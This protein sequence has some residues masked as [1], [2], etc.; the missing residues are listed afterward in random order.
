VGAIARLY[1]G[2]SKVISDAL[3]S[4]AEVKASVGGYSIIHLSV[5]GK[6]SREEPLLSYLK[7]AQGGPDDGRLTAAE[8]FGLPLDKASLVVLSACETGRAGVTYGNE[9][10]GMVRALLYAGADTLVLTYWEVDSASTALWMENFYQKAQTCSASE[11]ARLALRA[12]KSQP[13][14]VHP[15]YWAAFMLIG[16]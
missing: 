7:F 15:Y 8:M 10:L 3:A 2:R 5:H 12:V 16:G 6:F 11:A 14:Y 4:E 9:L 13:E 1:P